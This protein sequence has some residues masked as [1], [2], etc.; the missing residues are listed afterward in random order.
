MKI[1]VLGLD[2]ALCLGW[3]L[4]SGGRPREYGVINVGGDRVAPKGMWQL[5]IRSMHMEAGLLDVIG[6]TTPDV[7]AIEGVPFTRFKSPTTAEGYVLGYMH[8]QHIAA[9]T[10]LP[11][12]VLNTSSVK[13]HATGNGKADKTEMIRNVF[14]HWGIELLKSQD[15]IADAMWIADLGEKTWL[16][17]T[18]E[19]SLIALPLS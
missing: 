3:S 1:K 6:R 16:A 8:T 10:G 5:G 12:L 18:P 17:R 2:P 14:S 4:N 15:D 9:M 19:S 13:K 7:L 11:I